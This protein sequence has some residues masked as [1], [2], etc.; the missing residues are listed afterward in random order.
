MHDTHSPTGMIVITGVRRGQG[1]ARE[2]LRRENPE[3]GSRSG[4]LRFR[5]S[6]PAEHFQ[7][8]SKNAF[9]IGELLALP[10]DMRLSRKSS[11]VHNRIREM[12]YPNCNNP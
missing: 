7:P 4:F 1:S 5:P 6:G 2:T 10:A 12:V 11:I 9:A 3:R 8:L